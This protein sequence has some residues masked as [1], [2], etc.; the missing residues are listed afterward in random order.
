MK[1]Q[2][3]DRRLLAVAL[4]LL[5]IPV[6]YYLWNSRSVQQRREATLAGVP[7]FPAPHQA[8]RRRPFPVGAPAAPQEVKPPPPLTAATKQDPMTSF[9]LAPGSGAALIQVNALFNTPLFDRLRQC[10]PEQFRALDKLGR[11]L[12][13][14]LAYD[15]DRI[16]LAQDGVAMSGFFEGKP[17]AESMIGP[18]AGREE[19][20]GATI[21][22]KNGHCAAQQG[23]LVLSS[24]QQG[25]DCRALIDRALSPTPANAGDDLYGDVF[26]RSDLAGLRDAADAPPAIHALLDG[27]DGITLHANVWDSVALTLEAAPRSG[28]SANE[29]AQMALG[30]MAL[31]KGQLD[32][33]QVEFQTL[34]DLAKV[35]T[36]SGKL[37]LNLALPAQD[38]FDRFHFPC[39]KRDGGK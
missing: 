35:S 7:Q 6:A 23:N 18:G 39:E 30:A 14:D 32:E 31:V 1:K 19:Y 22:T 29:I 24:Q 16:G 13:V 26:M 33:D 38:L 28:R 3:R 11:T 34:A 4:L 2:G 12:G 21:F 5:A 37:E 36:D 8:P 17:V 10:L 20:R 25:A 15:V 27:L 9:V